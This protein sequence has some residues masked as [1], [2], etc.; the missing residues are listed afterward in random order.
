MQQQSPEK[1]ITTRARTLPIHKCLVNEDWQKGK[2]AQ[3]IVMR[4]HV[5][6]NVTIGIYLVDLLCLGVKDT[7][8]Y[9]NILPNEFEE[10][11]ED[12]PPFTEISYELAHNIV[13]AGHDFAMEFEIKPCAEFVVTQYILEE[14]NDKIP[15][16][17]IS[18]GDE[19][20]KP[21]LMVQPG[22][23]YHDALAKLRQHAGEGNY[24]FTIG[25]DNEEEKDDWEDDADGDYPPQLSDFELGTIDAIDARGFD[26]RTLLDKA[27]IEKRKQPE[28]LALNIEARLRLLES[29]EQEMAIITNDGLFAL[30]EF[31]L[32]KKSKEGLHTQNGFF[33]WEDADTDRSLKEIVLRLKDLSHADMADA[34]QNLP[35]HYQ[36]NPLLAIF[37]YEQLIISP[38][39]E[40]DT[41]PSPVIEYLRLHAPSCP[42]AALYL[43]FDTVA[44]KF[45]EQPATEA[46]RSANITDFLPGYPY[47]GN[48]ELHIYWLVKVWGYMVSDDLAN[49]ARFYK[50]AANAIPFST[51]LLA[52]Q[53]SFV[54]YIN[55]KVAAHMSKVEKNDET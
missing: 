29:L 38:K 15:L 23:N 12:G 22:A 50:L 9:F 4:R 33:T 1:Y 32:I 8:Y 13:Y 41:M 37:L 42:L 52:V 39:H 31:E 26:I 3:V 54:G 21:H 34:Y 6:G 27:A 47:Y 10:R 45:T 25:I 19:E 18:T 20:G 14:D 36:Q 44:W 17:D 30:P 11:I 55:E 24:H 35:V 51:A 16:I 28:I 53:F 40:N 43:A 46:A 5:T 7:H 49:A 48:Y 2:M